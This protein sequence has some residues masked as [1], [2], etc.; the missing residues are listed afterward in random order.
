[1]KKNLAQKGYSLINLVLM[2]VMMTLGVL[3]MMKLLK[4]ND[5]FSR[6]I[7][8]KMDVEQI[9]SL[10]H[11]MLSREGNCSGL[12]KGEKFNLIAGP[13]EIPVPSIKLP[14]SSTALAYVNQYVSARTRITNIVL[15]TIKQLGPGSTTYTSE[16]TFAVDAPNALGLNKYATGIKL[17]LD[18]SGATDERTI[19]S[20]GIDDPTTPSLPSPTPSVAPSPSPSPVPPTADYFSMDFGKVFTPISF[21]PPNYLDLWNRLGSHTVATGIGLHLDQGGQMVLYAKATKV[22]V[23][24]QNGI[25]TNT[26]SNCAANAVI[27]GMADRATSICVPL[28]PSYSLTDVTSHSVNV[29]GYQSA[30]CPSGKVLIGWSFASPTGTFRCAKLVGP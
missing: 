24:D 12:F 3:G 7:T 17:M 30:S 25:R 19:T 11:Q 26:S 28:N 27:V 22:P 14:D 20:C 23:T 15:G 2:Q 9:R 8:S 21:A 16:L 5:R 29:A 10:V 1:M 18:T 13:T 6:G 4:L